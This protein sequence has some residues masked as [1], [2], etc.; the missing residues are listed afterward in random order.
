MKTTL[1]SLSFVLAISVFASVGFAGSLPEGAFKG[2]NSTTKGF[3]NPDVMALILKKDPKSAG[4]FAI[5]AEYDRNT[6]RIA[7]E[8]ISL[9]NWVRRM[10]AFH[11]DKIND[12]SYSLKPLA[13]TATGEIVVNENASPAVLTLSTPNSIVGARLNLDNETI[14][15]NGKAVSTWEGYV[16]GAFWQSHE[17]SGSDYLKKSLGINTVLTVDQEAHFFQ[18]NVSGLFDIRERLP[19]MF[20]LTAKRDDNIGNDKV[21]GR[22]GVFV[23]IVN[24]KSFGIEAFTTEEFLLINPNSPSD[25]GFFYERH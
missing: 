9:T 17:A 13:V 6:G 24:W 15:F 8:K 19:G 22:I 23:D 1:K 3:L 20:T 11:M 4:Y 21:E 14:D 12:R 2:E 25:V 5:L 18:K 7:P 10:Y 16:A